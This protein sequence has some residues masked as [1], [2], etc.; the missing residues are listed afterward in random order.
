MNLFVVKKV[1]DMERYD[2]FARLIQ[3]ISYKNAETLFHL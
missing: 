1:S 3:K 2:P